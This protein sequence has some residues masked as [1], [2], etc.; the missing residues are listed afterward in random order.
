MPISSESNGVCSSLAQCHLADAKVKKAKEH[1]KEMF[2]EIRKHVRTNEE[3]NDIIIAGDYNQNIADK[4]VQKFHEDIGV[5]EIHVH[6]NKLKIEELDKTHKNGSKLIDSIAAT[7]GIMEYMEGCELISYNDIVETDHR[8]CVIDVNVEDY[9]KDE[10][11]EWDKTNHLMLNPAKR[12][13][14]EVF[15][16]TIEEQLETHTVEND[17]MIMMNSA[18]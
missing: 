6:V 4:E 7:S 1:R 11:N 8:A 3:I 16:E 14:R 18:A 10:F 2:E 9:F 15:V 5:K 13:H 12:S 17:L